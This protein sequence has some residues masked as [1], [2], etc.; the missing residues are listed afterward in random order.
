MYLKK[1]IMGK[2]RKLSHV[3]YKCEYH[4]VFVPK[5]RYR[6]LTDLVKSLV[7][8]DIISISQWKEVEVQE[9]NIQ[10]DHV[11]LV[12]SIPPKVSISDYM[13]ILK[14]KLAIRLFK[15]YPELKKKPYWGN[16]FWARGY[17]VSTI[18]LDAE[19]IKRYVKYQEDKEREDE[20]D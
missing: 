16:H 4:I 2:F 9:H 13:G 15:S 18:G 17:F 8:H 10:M 7:E 3:F 1:I 5:Y 12:C 14:G 20:N 11:H 6:I 19:M